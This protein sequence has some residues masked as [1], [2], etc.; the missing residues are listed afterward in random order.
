MR[1]CEG[2]K[3]FHDLRSRDLGGTYLF[4]IHLEIDGNLSLFEAHKLSENVE[5]KIKQE[6]SNAQ[7]I[8]HQDPFGIKEDRLDDIL[9]GKCEP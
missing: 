8:I 5:D 6:F 9:S 3:D 1:E 7:I 2:I 4:E